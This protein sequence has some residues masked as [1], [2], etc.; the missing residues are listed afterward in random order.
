M[1]KLKSEIAKRI[2][3]DNE[4]IEELAYVVRLAR[5]NV[6]KS[7]EINKE[8]G[9]ATRYNFLMVIKKHLHTSSLEDLLDLDGRIVTHTTGLQVLENQEE[10]HQRPGL[11]E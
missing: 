11:T 6:V 3:D 4:A 7:L 1:S 9:V 5:N 10:N 2:L 8:N